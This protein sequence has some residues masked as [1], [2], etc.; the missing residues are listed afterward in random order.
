MKKTIVAI[1]V[2]VLLSMVLAP[3]VYAAWPP[4]YQTV[5][6]SDPTVIATKVLNWFFGIVVIIAAIMLVAAGFTYVTSGGN[7]DKMKTALN[8]LIYALIGVAIALL[9]KGLVF[10]VCTF[11]G[12]TG[13][14]KFF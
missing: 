7:P 8:T 14:C 9:A 12:P 6:I 4:T 3:L 5:D 2:L 13:G 11:I 1:S 10:M